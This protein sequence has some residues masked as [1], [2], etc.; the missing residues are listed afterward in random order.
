MPP[1]Q[2][3][4]RCNQVPRSPAEKIKACG[5]HWEMT[6]THRTIKRASQRVSTEPDEQRTPWPSARRAGVVATVPQP[7]STRRWAIPHHVAI[8]GRTLYNALMN[9]LDTFFWNEARPSLWIAPPPPSP[10]QHYMRNHLQIL[11]NG[12]RQNLLQYFGVA[13]PW[14]ASCTTAQPAFKWGPA[15]PRMKIRP[16]H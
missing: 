10:H 2:T 13:F 8:D 15:P 6:K 5:T 1:F 16:W 14:M 11:Q 4:C 7:A 12:Q 3:A 9:V